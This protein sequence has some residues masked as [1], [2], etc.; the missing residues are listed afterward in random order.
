MT[1][2]FEPIH[3]PQ[4]KPP[5][6]DGMDRWLDHIIAASLAGVLLV[7]PW[8]MGGRH[9]LGQ[10][11]LVLLAVSGTLAWG[12]SAWRRSE[13][14]NWK[15]TPAHGL[16]LAA[17]ALVG[18]QLLPLP[19]PLLH[20][21]SPQLRRLLPLWS[22]QGAGPGSFGRWS[23]VSVVPAETGS[24]LVML[25]TY[26]L[27]FCVAMQHL[28]TVDKIERLLRWLA[29]SAVLLALVGLLQYLFG[30]G[31]FLWIYEHP[32]RTATGVALGPF[33]NA[34]HFAHLL[35][36][37]VGPLV[38]LLQRSIHAH[39]EA[40][41]TAG[42]WPACETATSGWTLWW[43]VLALGLVLL[44]GLMTFSRSGV[45]MMFLAAAV[46]AGMMFHA[47]LL[48][49]RVLRGLGIIFLLI[50]VCLAIHGYHRD[51]ERLGDFAGGSLE[52]LIKDGARHKIWL[53]D[54]RALGD[55]WVLGAGAGSHR[56][57][58][59]RYLSEP[60]PIEFRHVE[61]G[62][63]QVALET[64]L[65]GLALLIG[66]FAWCLSRC[67]VALRKPCSPR[68]YDCTTAVAAGL[69]VSGAHSLMDFV[70]FVPACMAV[71]TL[72]AACAVRLSQFTSEAAA[73]TPSWTLRLT[74]RAWRSPAWRWRWLAPGWS[75][76][77]AAP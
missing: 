3:A 11:V 26:G 70:W 52:K 68:V 8:F 43:R 1:K 38:W 27:L 54:V 10:L 73:R 23:R 6:L 21:L 49:R 9:P 76:S 7:A 44:A 20:C 58:Y 25:L 4:P 46:S 14:L 74:R 29:L 64:G 67:Y 5:T 19:E 51:S 47:G 77:G 41:R 45:A 72:L 28:R 48:G 60:R 32:Y 17:V 12:A 61:N 31:R 22:A 13:P 57:V 62:Y 55:F 37:G 2:Q 59:P 53:A 39:R 30:N 16:L 40:R 24:V 36:L 63:L 56:E 50:G 65:P 18:L 15:L 66:G 71:T 75:T 34:N 35:A 33:S 42:Q 69:L